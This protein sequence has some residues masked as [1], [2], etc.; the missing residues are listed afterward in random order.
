MPEKSA[1][2]LLYKKIDNKYYVVIVHPSGPMNR[3]NPWSIPKGKIE[4]NESIEDAARR[5]TK[6]ETG[7]VAGELYYLG[8]IRYKSR[9][10]KTVHCYAGKLPDDAEPKSVSWETDEVKLSELS[11]A[12]QLLH[13][14]Q[15]ELIDLL[16]RYLGIERETHDNSNSNDKPEQDGRIHCT[17]PK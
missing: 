10:A 7:V 3:N 4:E 16:E 11:E 17:T 15:S 6:E 12:K 9:S 2:T 13:K 14:D 1:G 5:E 8:S